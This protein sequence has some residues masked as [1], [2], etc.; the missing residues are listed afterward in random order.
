MTACP[1]CPGFAPAVTSEP[2]GSAG[3]L[4]LVAHRCA[5]GHIVAVTRA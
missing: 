1:H 5:A 4:P 3:D 2:W